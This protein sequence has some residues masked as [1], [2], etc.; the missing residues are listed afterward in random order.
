MHL[1]G[2]DRGDPALS[3]RICGFDSGLLLDPVIPKMFKNGSGLFLHGTHYEGG[4]TKQLVG[5]VSV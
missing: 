2:N 1:G 3:K 5:P 4:T